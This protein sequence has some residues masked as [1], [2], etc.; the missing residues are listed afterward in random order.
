VDKDLEEIP[1]TAARAP[2]TRAEAVKDGEVFGEEKAS[3]GR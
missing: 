1:E 3:R 2:V